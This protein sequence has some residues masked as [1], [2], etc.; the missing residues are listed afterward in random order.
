VRR[1]RSTRLAHAVSH[2]RR[3]QCPAVSHR[4]RSVH[5]PHQ[6]IHQQNYEQRD[7]ETERQRDR[8]TE[9][10]NERYLLKHTHRPRGGD[11]ERER[12]FKREFK[13]QSK[14]SRDR[15]RNRTTRVPESTLGRES[16]PLCV[17]WILGLTEEVVSGIVRETELGH[18]G[19]AQHNC[20]FRTKTCHHSAI[21]SG[22]E[23]PPQ[24]YT[25][26]Q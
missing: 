3:S 7:R 21:L 6:R 4:R 9:R 19:F 13:R 18:V 24:W 20:A 14:I 12:E 11:R 5:L 16:V 17:V 26:R 8:E 22:A 23:V 2:P 1:C 25:H 10:K 15:T